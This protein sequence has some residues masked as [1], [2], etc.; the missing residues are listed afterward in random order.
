MVVKD[1]FKF[2]LDNSY[3]R[4]GSGR[5]FE[6]APD[7]LDDVALW[8]KDFLTALYDH[9]IDYLQNDLDLKSTTVEFI[10]S[11][12]TSWNDK[13]KLARI[14]REIVSN[15]GFGVDNVIMRLTEGEAAAVFTA[16]HHKKK[17][18]VS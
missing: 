3:Q 2:Y 5:N 9:I 18:K 4:D 8:Y 10:F 17:F 13:S 11:L 6:D 14:F 16:K 7:T 15:T 1:M 12:P